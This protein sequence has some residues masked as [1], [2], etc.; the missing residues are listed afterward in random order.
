M[1]A[2]RNTVLYVH[3]YQSPIG[4]LHIAVDRIGRLHRLSFREFG[5]ELAGFALEDNKYA[6]GEVEYQ[7]DEY[8]EGKRHRFTVEVMLSGTAF[9]LSVWNRLMKVQ[10]GDTITYGALARKIGR[11]EAARAVGN[12]V[13]SNPTPIVIPCH[14]VVP[15][16]GGIGSYAL[17]TTSGGGSMKE[18]LLDLEGSL[19]KIVAA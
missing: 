14:R 10:Y 3:A 2:D 12:A 18:H 11:R 1:N 9:Q 15:A 7:L 19:A 8:F 17:R 5:D 4:R 13:A 16:S 6:C